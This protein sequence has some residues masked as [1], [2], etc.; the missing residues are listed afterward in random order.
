LKL[1]T[2]LGIVPLLVLGACGQAEDPCAGQP[3]DCRQAIE[4]ALERLGPGG[5]SIVTGTRVQPESDCQLIDP[6]GHRDCPADVTYAA[7][8]TFDL[9]GGER[10]PWVE[11]IVARFG[12]E[13]LA[14]TWDSRRPAEP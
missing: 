7:R 1:A 10:F 4:V 8:V 9:T 5:R 14:A 6:E 12:T 13:P 11:V 2:T 3:P